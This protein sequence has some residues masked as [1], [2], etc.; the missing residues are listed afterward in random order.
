MY[1]S[2][3]LTAV[4]TLL[5]HFVFIMIAFRLMTALRFDRFLRP[6]HERESRL[7]LLFIAI[8]LGFGVSE[9]VLSVVS[10]AAN[11]HYLL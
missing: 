8:T 5:S 10:S 6:G 3:G 2:L 1:R 4:L 9:F 11:L 7:L